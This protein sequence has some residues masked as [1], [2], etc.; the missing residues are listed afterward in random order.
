MRE[1]ARAF[2]FHAE[3][4]SESDSR[5][6]K[7]APE[8][9]R[10]KDMAADITRREGS[11]AKRDRA[12]RTRKLSDRGNT[13][14]EICSRSDSQQLSR[15]RRTGR[16]RTSLTQRVYPAVLGQELDESR[17]SARNLEDRTVSRDAQ[18]PKRKE[19]L[20]VEVRRLSV[21]RGRTGEGEH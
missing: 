13:F 6:G 14:T 9:K 12:L 21:R 7:M 18:F 15:M 3:S 8:W 11:L 2:I 16:T 20:D 1:N 17:R 5:C 4:F 19:E 10:L